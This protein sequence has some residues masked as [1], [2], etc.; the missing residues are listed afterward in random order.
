VN[1]PEKGSVVFAASTGNPKLAISIRSKMRSGTTAHSPKRLVDGITGRAD[2]TSKGK[3]TIMLEL[4]LSERVKELT[5]GK[6]TP[7][8]AKPNTVPDFSDCGEALKKRR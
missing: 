7:T 3:I 2:Y 4:Y 6:Q 5:G 8:T 1:S